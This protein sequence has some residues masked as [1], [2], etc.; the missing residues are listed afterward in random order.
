MAQ[1]LGE[2]GEN[3]GLLVSAIQVVKYGNKQENASKWMKPKS[4][5]TSCKKQC[6]KIAQKLYK[7]SINQKAY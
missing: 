3:K 1:E 7:W 6:L 5:S 4:I 2:K